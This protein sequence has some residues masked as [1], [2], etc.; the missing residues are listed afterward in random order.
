ML[1]GNLASL[2]ATGKTMAKRS[3][4]EN[5][6]VPIMAYL[7]RINLEE[8]APDHPFVAGAVVLGMHPKSVPS[9]H[10]DQGQITH[11]EPNPNNSQEH[12]GV[13]LGVSLKNRNPK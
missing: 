12:E 11:V 9:V 8:E 2:A 3:S 6:G 10:E 13:Y 4:F 1:R 7:G 5:E